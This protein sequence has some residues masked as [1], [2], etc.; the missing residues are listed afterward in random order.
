MKKLINEENEWDHRIEVTLIEGPADYI[1]MGQVAVA[2]KKMKRHKA[3]GLVTE[4]IQSTEDI[5]TQWISHLCHSIVKEGCIQENWKSS[6]LLPIYN[7]KGDLTECRS[8]RGIGL[9]EHAVKVVE[10]IF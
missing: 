9:L 4:M 5:G 3:P 7:G 10:R 6:M 2:L 1:T 8:Y